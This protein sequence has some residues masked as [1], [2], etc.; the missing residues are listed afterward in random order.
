[1]E[2]PQGDFLCVL[3]PNGSGKSTFARLLNAL[4]L[5]LEGR[6]LIKGMDTR[7]PSNLWS[8]RQQVGMVFQNPDN[9][10]VGTVVEEDVAFGLEN[11]GVEPKEI[12]RRV[13][14]VLDKVRMLDYRQHP[15][16][17]LS[18]GQKQ[19]VAIAGILAM[20]PSAIIL[21]EPTSLLDPK[22]RQEVRQILRELNKEGITIILI[23]HL[24]EEALLAQN[25][26]VLLEGKLFLYGPPVEVLR[27]TDKLRLAHLEPPTA[28][29]LDQALRDNGLPLG[30]P[31]L[32]LEDLSENLCALKQKA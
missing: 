6:V 10:I 19:R 2:I 12:R 26:M 30:T 23:T 13:E 14:D 29:R 5:P 17:L 15:P 21:D 28:L 24:M 4:I 11:L 9:Q 3:G 27:N 32:R 20:R 25:V 8:V 16:H 18:G 31:S 22:G 7:E 1:M